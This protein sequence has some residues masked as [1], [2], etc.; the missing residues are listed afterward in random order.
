MTKAKKPRIADILNRLQDHPFVTVPED[1]P[2]QEV[3]EIIR[4]Q[5]DVRSIFVTDSKGR[6]KGALSLGKL[7]RTITASRT[8]R[9][10]NTRR[11]LRCLTCS[12]AGDIMTHNLITASL[13]DP[14][15]EVTDRML[16]G[17]IK[18]I[19]VVDKNGGII[20]NAG[21]LDLWSRL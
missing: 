11:L 12:R 21:L 4:K 8:G 14:V 9:D 3:A 13:D 18:E 2:V 16:E 6:L 7:I 5:P 1:M 19:P 20:R 15:D 10:F 17:N